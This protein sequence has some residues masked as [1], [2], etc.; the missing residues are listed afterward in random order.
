[1]SALR[2]KMVEA[3]LVRGF[4]PRTHESYLA[5]V[6]AL[7]RF[8]R[9]CPAELD[10]PALQAF[11]VHLVVE[12][13]LSA[14]SCRLIYNGIR[15]LYLQ[16]L[17]W[18]Q[19]DVPLAL[20]KRPQRIPE[21]LTRAEVASLLIALRNGKHRMLL[22]V[23]YGCGLRVSELVALKVRHID[24]ERGW[25]RVEQGKGGKDR[26]VLISPS[27]LDRLRQYWRRYRPSVWLFPSREPETALSICSAQRVYRYAC[28]RAQLAKV[29]GIHSLRHA[30]ATHQ[31]EDG[32]PLHVLQRQLGHGSL[33]STTRYLHWVPGYHSAPLKDN[34]LLARLESL[35]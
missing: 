17:Q 5:S 33:R 16:V 35:P 20:P 24:G 19:F 32:L 10:V 31:L 3:M 30:Y 11:F 1:M 14:A 29:G 25:L 12:R 8:H 9:R 34:D 27:L 7:A 18:P 13:G 28:A 23:C 21:L 4:S 15:F 6:T 26:L 2:S 22:T